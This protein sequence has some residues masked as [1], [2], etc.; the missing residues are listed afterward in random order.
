[1]LSAGLWLNMVVLR[2]VRE[3]M[4]DCGVFGATKTDLLLNGFMESVTTGD[5][6]L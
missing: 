6:W 2:R 5:T 3:A 1:M 4:E